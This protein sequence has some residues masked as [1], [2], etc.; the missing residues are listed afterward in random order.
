MLVL[1]FAGIH[2]GLV[3]YFSKIAQQMEL[4]SVVDGNVH[5]SPSNKAAGLL[6][7]RRVPSVREHG[8]M[9]TCLREAASAACAPKLA[10]AASAKAGNAVADFFNIPTLSHEQRKT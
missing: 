6:G 3:E 10:S 7:E 4:I 2:V 5:K 8:Q 9:T 1:F